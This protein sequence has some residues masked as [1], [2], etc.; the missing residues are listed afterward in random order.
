MPGDF[1][2]KAHGLMRLRVAT[3]RGLVFVAFAAES[4]V[5]PLEAYL[6]PEVCA[7]LDRI[8]ARPLELLGD[9]R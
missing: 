8:F 9:E 1:D 3:Y 5:E 6:G 4:A 7:K 2:M